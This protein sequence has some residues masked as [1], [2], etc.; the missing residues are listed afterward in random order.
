MNKYVSILSIVLLL[1]VGCKEE[2]I[3]GEVTAELEP[4][5]IMN[6]ETAT[7]TVNLKNT[8]K[9]AANVFLEIIPEDKS[10]LQVIYPGEL[11][12]PLQSGEEMTKIIRLRGFTDYTSTKY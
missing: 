8:G 10:K 2:M 1:L 7:F 5:T 6:G 11:E 4:K 12:Q 9:I 3:T